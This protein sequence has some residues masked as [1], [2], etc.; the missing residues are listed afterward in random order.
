MKN[1]FFWI[2]L[3]IVAIAAIL[4]WWQY[5]ASRPAKAVEKTTATFSG[6]DHSS[7]DVV[8]VVENIPG[9]TVFPSWLVSTGVA[10]QLTGAGPYTIFVPTDGS[11]ADL[12]TGTFTNLS[13]A[14]KKRLVEYHIVAG[15]AI[16]A[17]AQDQ[18]A[19]GVQA[20]SG[21]TLDFSYATGKVP[22]VNGATI[23]AEY[24][25]GNGVVYLISSVLMPPATR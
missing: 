6:T 7:P 23:L 25:A 10:A 20:L 12:K 9:A 16:D 24:A 4:G 14:A 3:L 5:A 15:R 1:K 18:T 11:I 13:S 8:S 21:D 19:G 2:G 22:M 17:S